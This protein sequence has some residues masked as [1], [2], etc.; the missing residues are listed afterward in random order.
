MPN[1]EA[2][3]LIVQDLSKKLANSR[4][5]VLADYRGLKVSEV[6]QL[7]SELRK[8]GVEFRVVKN[9]ITTLAVRQLGLSGLELYLKGPTAIAF[10]SED[11]VAP[12]KVLAEF[13]KTHK[14]LSIKAG[15]IEGQVI[16]IEGV[17]ALAELPSR[18]VLLAKVA[19]MFQAPISSW[20]RVL[21][22]PI[23]SL[24]YVLE[25]IRQQKEGA[26]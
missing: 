13:A 19:G 18:E 11:P 3:Q 20:V 23:S 10:G 8:A 16:G 21:N 17:M 9:T 14:N 4:S 25:S 5:I 2:K 12:A 24:A 7:R 15:V 22:A 26:A 1:L 6:T